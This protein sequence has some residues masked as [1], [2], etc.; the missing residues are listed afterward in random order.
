[1][2]SGVGGTSECSLPPLFQ[3]LVPR[4]CVTYASWSNSSFYV[5]SNS[6]PFPLIVE[7][8][9]CVVYIIHWT[10]VKI[11]FLLLTRIRVSF[12][13]FS[14]LQG[15]LFCYHYFCCTGCS[16]L[17]HSEIFYKYILLYDLITSMLLLFSSHVLHFLNVLLWLNLLT[18]LAF[19]EVKKRA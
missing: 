12:L 15:G 8:V 14:F 19:Q 1:M 5:S 18:W 13:L 6:H 7:K 10:I 4:V 3:P 16:T 17:K 11:T 2:S 9:G